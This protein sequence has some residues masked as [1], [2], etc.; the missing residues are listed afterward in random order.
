MHTRNREMAKEHELAAATHR[1]DQE[2]NEKAITRPA[3]GTHNELLEYA[4]RAHE[5]ARED[6]NK[7]GQIGSLEMST[8]YN[9]GSHYELPP[10]RLD[11]L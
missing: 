9:D 10:I 2:R 7:S 8:R 11:S 5:L 3:T 1:T 6:E 4:D